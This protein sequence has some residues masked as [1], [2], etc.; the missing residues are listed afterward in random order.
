[1]RIKVWLRQVSCSCP[2]LPI[3]LLFSPWLLCLS[4]SSVLFSTSLFLCVR[5]IC[6]SAEQRGPRQWDTGLGSSSA[7]APPPYPP[8]P[9]PQTSCPSLVLAQWAVE[10]ALPTELPHH[11]FYQSTQTP[12]CW[13]RACPSP[14][15]FCWEHLVQ[16]DCVVPLG[17]REGLLT[18]RSTELFFFTVTHA[19]H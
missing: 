11:L 12:P 3:N 2:H 8:V 13:E 18:P 5:L 1:M 14:R 7:P 10:T 19:C 15:T 6:V 17:W 4:F 9:C 16:S